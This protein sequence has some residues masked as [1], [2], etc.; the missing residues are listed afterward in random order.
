M[1]KQTPETL[2]YEVL[3]NNS[4][5]ETLEF[6]INDYVKHLEHHLCQRFGDVS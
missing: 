4:Q 6:L 3:I 1:A 2:K 5:A